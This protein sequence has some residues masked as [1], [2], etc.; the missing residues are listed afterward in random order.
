LRKRGECDEICSVKPLNRKID[1]RNFLGALGVGAASLP[2][3]LLE[4]RCGRSGRRPNIIFILADDLGYG[5]VGCYG[6]T[7]IRTPN[8]DRLAAAGLRFSQFY[9]GSPVCA[10]SRCVLLTGKHTGHA[11]IRDNDEMGERGDVWHDPSLE[12]QRPLL[13]G[14]TTIGTILQGA[15]YATAA[16][17]KWGLGGP[18]S[19][20]EPNRQG[21]D[22]FYG[23]LCQ[24]IAHNYY[25]THLWRNGEKQILEGNTY[26]YPHQKFP[27]H[28]DPDDREAYK[29]YMGRQY[30]MD[31][32]TE[33]ALA[34]IRANKSRPFFL[35]FAPP[36]PHAALQVPEDSLKEY[37][38]AF[39]ETPYLGEKGYLPHRT[40]RAAYAAM[41]TRLDREVGRIMTILDELGIGRNTLVMF[42][43]DNGP[44]FNGGTDSAFFQSAG[45][46]RG[47]KTTLYEGGIRVPFIAR[48]PGQIQ[49]D[50][51]S[52][53]VAAFLDVLP[54][55]TDILGFKP[56]PEIDGLSFLPTLR[57]RPEQQEVH[58]DLYWEY[59][60][61][62]AVR[63]G[64]W[65]AVR[66]RV[67][68]P[69]ELYD[70]KNDIA[71]KNDI[72]AERPDV[73]GKIKEIMASARTESDLFPL[74][75]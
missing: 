33:E 20:G 68:A 58:D 40:P 3:L 66:P 51:V 14:T 47:L 28:W 17:G 42:S 44:T 34:F 60:G 10:P 4:S 70:L 49:P 61:G 2:L 7:K 30:S 37:E 22:L 63:F 31:L 11:Y 13:P 12:G 74:K 41:V 27:A 16:V 23:Y 39:S 35:Y 43:S 36:I 69:L 8:I 26:F 55:L 56:P 71:E 62:Q 65:K 25:P 73:A 15:G 24:R 32:M 18:G 59:S 67:D 64:D 46:L 45:P 53:H 48:W 29:P 6:Q 75:R 5:E 72:A 19:S 9:S 57:G 54:T 21:F 52:G 38:G 50:S 1:R